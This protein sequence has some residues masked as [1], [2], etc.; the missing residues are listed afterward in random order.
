MKTNIIITLVLCFVCTGIIQGQ[1]YSSIIDRAITNDGAW[2][3]ELH[4]D[5]GAVT[6][7][8]IGCPNQPRRQQILFQKTD[9]NG[10][11][12]YEKTFDYCDSISTELQLKGPLLRVDSFFF[13]LW[14]PFDNSNRI[15]LSKFDLELNEIFTQ[16]YDTD[17]VM[18]SSYVVPI[19]KNRLILFYGQYSPDTTGV[20]RFIKVNY[21]GV[22]LERGKDRFPHD[23]YKKRGT[24]YTRSINLTNDNNLLI[25]IET[26]EFWEHSQYI[27]EVD[28]FFNIVRD[29]HYENLDELDTQDCGLTN[30]NSQ[31]AAILPNDNL[32]VVNCRD[33]IEY[34]WP[35]IML[36]PSHPRLTAYTPEGRIIWDTTF[37]SYNGYTITD[38]V[39]DGEGSIYCCG[40][41][42][43][44][45]RTDNTA[46]AF[47]VKMTMDG[48]VEWLRKIYPEYAK[49]G[50]Y[51]DMIDIEYLPD[52]GVIAS[53][54]ITYPSTIRTDI[55]TWVIRL[56]SNGCI[57]PGCTEEDILLSTSDDDGS[58]QSLK[59]VP[60]LVSPN[61][62]KAEVQVQTDF[63]PE[64]GD[65]FVWLDQ[66]GRRIKS[67]QLH[68]Y[69][70]Q[71]LQAPSQ[72][73][74]YFLTLY[75]QGKVMHSE[76]VVVEGI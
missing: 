69:K 30:D 15:L 12:E 50:S 5:G 13:L 18:I 56:D 31:M 20:E 49:Y 36:Y 72:K 10:Q 55:D 63:I 59:Q 14:F 37:I 53:G 6:A 51:N 27:I 43:A 3:M 54:L 68:S 61:P 1:G 22:E 60:F 41:V 57:T 75:R 26:A 2:C 23:H 66:M 28:T 45:D 4:P 34:T 19:N 9:I 16:S 7:C 44:S 47:F 62:A 21:D 65:Y 25:S 64:K 17:G 42:R 38:M 52:G 39:V 32:V 70:I 35:P 73:G 58:G 71:T 74:V 33:T 48:K 8:V 24:K 76:K 29:Y 40:S 46:G 11:L 67:H